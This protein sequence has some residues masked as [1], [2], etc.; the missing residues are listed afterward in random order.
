MRAPSLHLPHL[1]LLRIRYLRLSLVVGR[2]MPC[3]FEPSPALL[4]DSPLGSTIHM[5]RLGRLSLR[6]RRPLLEVSQ[7]VDRQIW[8][9]RRRMR[10]NV[11]RRLLRQIVWYFIVVVIILS[12]AGL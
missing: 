12:I 1:M 11:V 6:V 4:R 8:P 10:A 3:L 7:Q 9:F 2:L 5:C